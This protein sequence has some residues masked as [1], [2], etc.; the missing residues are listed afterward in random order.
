MPG[1]L[2]ENLVAEQLNAVS[3]VMDYVEFHFNGPV[4]RALSFPVLDYQERRVRFPEPG[5]RDA[6]CSLI[7]SDVAAV[8][9]REHDRIELRTKQGHILTIPL[10]E[11]SYRG[12][13]AAHF[14]PADSSG[15]L[16]VADMMI[17]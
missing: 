2:I 11:A 9:V 12:A 1:T 4:L 16:R 13:E 10:D 6:L 3:F 15:R 14:I 5:S 8:E 17:W 7:G